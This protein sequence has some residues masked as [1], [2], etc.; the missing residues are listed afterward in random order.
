MKRLGKLID[1][2]NVT[3]EANEDLENIGTVP[4]VRDPVRCFGENGAVCTI[5]SGI[6]WVVPYGK[7]PVVCPNYRAE[8]DTQ[9]VKALRSLSGMDVF[10]GKTFDTFIIDMSD[11]YKTQRDYTLSEINNLV[12]AKKAAEGLC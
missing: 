6:G 1:N 2:L 11:K 5:C 12:F 4:A 7:P 10:S 8:K 9:R 3:V